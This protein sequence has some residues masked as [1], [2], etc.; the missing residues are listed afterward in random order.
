MRKKI[1]LCVGAILAFLMALMTIDVIWGVFTRYVVGAQASWSEELARFLLI[2]I[3]VLGAAYAAGQHLHL[4]IDILPAS[5]EGKPKKRLENVISLVIILFVITALI[6]GGSRLVYIT[7][8]LG[9]ASA[10]LQLPLSVVY[11]IVPLS[12][13]LILYYKLDD[14]AKPAATE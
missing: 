8:K 9:Q 6:I 1:D 14:L 10:A 13:L 12:G 5:L 2:W 3:G 7:Y 11:A 4:S